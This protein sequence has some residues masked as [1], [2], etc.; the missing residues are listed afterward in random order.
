MR[1]HNGFVE[2]ALPHGT[3]R[4][5]RYDLGLKGARILV[6]EGWRSFWWE[7]KAYTRKRIRGKSGSSTIVAPASE[8]TPEHLDE[9]LWNTNPRRHTGKAFIQMNKVD[10]V[11]DKEEIRKKLGD[12]IEEIG[13]GL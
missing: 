7:F 1:Y 5:R 6:N 11:A 3:G 4:R 8:Y 10:M 2:R 13:R 9:C 12:I